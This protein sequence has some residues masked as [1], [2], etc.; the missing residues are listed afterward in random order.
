MSSRSGG[1][2][3]FLQDWGLDLDVER[4]PS[5]PALSRF[6]SPAGPAATLGFGAG[7]VTGEVRKGSVTG[8]RALAVKPG[9][10]S[11]P[12]PFPSGAFPF[13]AL[14]A[15]LVLRAPQAWDFGRDF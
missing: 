9:G 15:R 4:V 13:P 7:V 10:F 12:Q 6:V 1:K 14:P 5:A 2:T 3:T 8:Y 11:P